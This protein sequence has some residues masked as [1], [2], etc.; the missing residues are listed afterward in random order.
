MENKRKQCLHLADACDKWLRKLQLLPQEL[1]GQSSNRAST[2]Q[3]HCPS[4]ESVLL[5]ASCDIR[6]RSCTWIRKQV[7]QLE[8][9]FQKIS[10][11]FLEILLFDVRA[12]FFELTSKLFD[13]LI[14]FIK[15]PLF[16]FYQTR[17]FLQLVSQDLL[18]FIHLSITSLSFLPL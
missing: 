11:R 14:V 6:L 16:A 8:K 1:S 15:H 10:N 17:V 2:E 12:R 5:I 4:L 18:L 7:G 3:L 13:L 9:N